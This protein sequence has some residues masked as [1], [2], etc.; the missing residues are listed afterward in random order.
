[1]CHSVKKKQLRTNKKEKTTKT[2]KE[3]Q[4]YQYKRNKKIDYLDKWLIMLNFALG[5]A[6]NSIYDTIT[7]FKD[8]NEKHQTVG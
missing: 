5:F 3:V 4:N 1:M 8:L 2:R 7:T 6:Q